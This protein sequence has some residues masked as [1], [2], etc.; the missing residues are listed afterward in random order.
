MASLRAWLIAVLLVL[1]TAWAATAEALSE[2]DWTA[3]WCGERGL[4]Y[5]A[6]G[7]GRRPDA[8][9][10]ATRSGRTVLADCI[11]ELVVVEV[12]FARKY[13]EGIG[14][15]MDYADY[16]RRLGVLLLIVEDAADCRYVADAWHRVATNHLHL[17][18]ITTGPVQCRPVIE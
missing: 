2:A 16:A 14:Q 3:Q 7:D 13:H 17:M 4:T 1:T 9:E 12:D 5:D 15:A 18:V 6:P 8:L 10:L 11:N